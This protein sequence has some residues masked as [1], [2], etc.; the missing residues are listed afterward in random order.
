MLILSSTFGPL[1]NFFL[2]PSVVRQHMPKNFA[3]T[4]WRMLLLTKENHMLTAAQNFQ[5]VR[6]RI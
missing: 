3:V 1:S 5:T 4:I 6:Y 2:D